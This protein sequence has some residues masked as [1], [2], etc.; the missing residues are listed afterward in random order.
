MLYLN[1]VHKSDEPFLILTSNDTNIS[2]KVDEDNE[3]TVFKNGQPNRKLETQPKSSHLSKDEFS[4]VFD[5]N[6]STENENGKSKGHTD[7]K[8]KM[9]NE[10][11]QDNLMDE[12]FIV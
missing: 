4:D 9:F 8:Y 6:A 7:E 5:K 10:D 12:I 2:G 1:L 11:Y 3:P